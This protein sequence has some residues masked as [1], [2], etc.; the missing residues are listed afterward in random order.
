MV[1]IITIW[2]LD[3]DSVIIIIIIMAALAAVIITEVVI[4][5]IGNKFYII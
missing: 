2:V 1:L 3:L 5:D 4:M